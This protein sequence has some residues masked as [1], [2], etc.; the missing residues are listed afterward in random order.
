MRLASYLT[1][2]F[3][4]KP[5]I[6]STDGAAAGRAA[7]VLALFGAVLVIAVLVNLG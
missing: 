2:L 1:K 4:A 6:T 5:P 7:F 3:A